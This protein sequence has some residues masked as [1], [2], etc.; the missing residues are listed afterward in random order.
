M[1]ELKFD[2]KPKRDSPLTVRLPSAVLEK[3]KEIAS[4]Y[5][6]SQTEVI[7]KLIE[8]AHEKMTAKKKK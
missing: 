6:V 3:L 4:R 2:K 7:E 5:D 8:D 1:D